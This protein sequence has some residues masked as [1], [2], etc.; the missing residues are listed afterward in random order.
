MS[1]LYIQKWLDIDCRMRNC[2]NVV[3]IY[4]NTPGTKGRLVSPQIWVFTVQLKVLRIQYKTAVL[5]MMSELVLRQTCVWDCISVSKWIMWPVW[6][7]QG[8]WRPHEEWN[9]LILS[10]SSKTC[11]IKVR[12]DV[13]LSLNMG[14]E[15]IETH[16][17]DLSIYL[18]CGQ[19]GEVESCEGWSVKVHDVAPP[20]S[21]GTYLIHS[22]VR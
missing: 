18:V 11:S 7:I 8:A 5:L 9:K 22:W 19:W 10:C 3:I 14:E 12:E 20:P 21:K 6:D 1:P 17:I 16:N 2:G 13:R 15:Y 4:R